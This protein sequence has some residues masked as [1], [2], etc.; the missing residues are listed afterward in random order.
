MSYP[1]Y[2]NAPSYSFNDHYVVKDGQQIFHLP[3]LI[4]PGA[5]TP[6]TI[7][8]DVP[9]IGGALTLGKT[10][11]FV[12]HPSA[13]QTVGNADTVLVKSASVKVKSVG[14]VINNLKLQQGVHDGQHI[15]LINEGTD[16]ISF[17]ST[18]ATSRIRGGGNVVSAG[19]L[20]HYIWNATDSLWYG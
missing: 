18:E 13:V 15:W 7:Y 19:L 6:G 14:G 9:T 10:T 2:P 3:R 12:T 5:Y 4:F 17:D 11:H 1:C 20:Y 16:Q 8:L